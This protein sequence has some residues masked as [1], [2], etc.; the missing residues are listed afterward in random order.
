MTLTL[1]GLPERLPAL[2]HDRATASQEWAVAALQ[3]HSQPLV[4][5]RAGEW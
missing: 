5:L 4:E 2:N 1:A 3:A